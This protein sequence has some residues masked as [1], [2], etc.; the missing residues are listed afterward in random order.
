MEKVSGTFKNNG[1]FYLKKNGICG[2]N[3]INARP[4]QIGWYYLDNIQ[5]SNNLLPSQNITLYGLIIESPLKTP[6]SRN[7]PKSG[8]LPGFQ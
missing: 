4:Y 8:F 5:I 3:L 6:F 1:I 7:G 2:T